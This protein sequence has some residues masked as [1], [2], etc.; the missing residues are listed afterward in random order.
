MSLLPQTTLAFYERYCADYERYRSAAEEAGLR[1]T[2]ALAGQVHGLHTIVPRAKEPGSLLDK[3][4]RKEYPDPEKGLKDLVGVRVV[5][6]YP[7]D[8]ARAAALL[9]DCF[10][11]DEDESFDRLDQ[12]EPTVF[13]YRSIHLVA[14]LPPSQVDVSKHLRDLWFEIQV[15]G[16]LQHAWAT[17]DQE[18]R[19]KSGVEFPDLVTRRFAAIAG[20]LETLDREFM[21]LRASRDDL[22]DGHRRVYADGDDQT[23]TLDAARLAGCL[24]ALRPDGPVLHESATALPSSRGGPE[25]LICDAL[26][27]VGIATAS[28]LKEALDG[29]AAK[30]L[31]EEHAAA[32]GTE[33]AALSHLVVCIVLIWAENSDVIGKQFPELR[34]DPDLAGTLG[35]DL[36]EQ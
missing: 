12:L 19:Y 24:Q 3:L 25:K 28:Q 26:A 5:T 4:R 27:M 21:A 36:E 17:V 22:V 1:V 31:L 18:V 29:K 10:E 2:R 15:R 30:D 8:A 16:L 34:F 33:P 32:L 9:K 23:V 20:T 14:R 6:Y 11:I 13:G 7:D 35:F